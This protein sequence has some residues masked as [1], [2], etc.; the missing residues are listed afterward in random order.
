MSHEILSMA[1]A[2]EPQLIQDRRYLH[3]NPE[4]SFEEKNTMRYIC[5]RLDKLG[6]SYQSGIAVTGVLAEVR[7]KDQGKCL[8]IRADMDALPLEEKSET[9]YCST[10]PGVMHACG[11]DVHMAI[12]LSACELI[13]KLRD[14]FSGTVKFVF[15]PGEETT[16]GAKPMIDAGILENPKVDTCI[17]LHVDTDLPSGSI[18][19]KSGS[20][21]A[22]PDD[23]YITVKGKGGHGAEPQNAIDPIL[24]AAQIVTQLQSIVSR[25]IDPFAS[26]VITIGSIHAGNATNVIPDTAKLA[27]TARSLDNATRTFLEKKIET[28][29]QTVCASFGAEY[30][31]EFQKLFPPLINNECISELIAESAVRCLGEENCI[32]G[33]L[34]T[35]AG[36]D[37]AYFSQE[38]PSALFK[39]GCRNEA[40]GITA[41]IHNSLFDVDEEAM[42]YGLAIF[43]DFALHFLKN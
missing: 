15:Q 4:L 27:G 33:G 14:R 41:P 22:S 16:G 42:K 39:L 30:E 34:P 38:V 37:F 8:L 2:M 7:G 3:Q 29:V 9:S 5:K 19:I 18:R 6:I 10:K 23:F 32:K 1:K 24:I 31:Y 35:M 28:I 21:Y 36:E 40:K 17:A 26:A 12:L 11:H 43:A 20:A 25:N 13:N